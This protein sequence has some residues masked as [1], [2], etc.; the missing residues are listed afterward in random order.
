MNP[1]TKVVFKSKPRFPNKASNMIGLL[2]AFFDFLQPTIKLS[3]NLW[4][5]S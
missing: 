1:D 3:A 2:P 5:V 4:Y